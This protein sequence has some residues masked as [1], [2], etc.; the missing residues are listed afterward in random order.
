M[1]SLADLAKHFRHHGWVRLPGLQDQAVVEV[2][3][4]A[5]L[6]GFADAPAED[7]PYGVRDDTT[8]SDISSNED[9]AAVLTDVAFE[10]VGDRPIV[11][12]CPRWGEAITLGKHETV[13]GA[14]VGL[15]R[16]RHVEGRQVGLERVHFL[17]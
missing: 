7:E 3:T 5:L 9:E 6:L 1:A 10:K 4:A 16:I 15:D 2:E 12:L 13:F 11:L 17:V 8:P 14:R